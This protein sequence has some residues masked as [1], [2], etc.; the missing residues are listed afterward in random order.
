M[1]EK[2][3]DLRVL[4]EALASL[5]FDQREVLILRRLQG[6]KYKE[7]ADVTGCSLSAVKV[8]AHRALKELRIVFF[9]IAKELAS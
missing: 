9:K 7:I 2:E 3:W 6:M 5:P 4:Q 8:R 1:L